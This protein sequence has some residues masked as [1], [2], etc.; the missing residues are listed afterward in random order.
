[1]VDKVVQIFLAGDSNQI[2]RL[3]FVF[4]NQT[5]S[6]PRLIFIFYLLF[7]RAEM[8]ATGNDYYSNILS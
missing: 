3:I 6:R 8:D 4:D 1:M 7:E 5:G 2:S